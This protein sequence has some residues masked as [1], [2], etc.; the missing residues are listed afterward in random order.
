MVG[1]AHGLVGRAH[2]RSRWNGRAS[3]GSRSA[4]AT[5][6][7]SSRK[8]R[9]Q[10]HRRIPPATAR[11]AVRRPAA[12]IRSRHLE[13][14][15]AVSSASSSRRSTAQRSARC[16]C[17]RCAHAG[18]PSGRTAARVRAARDAAPAAPAR[19]RE[20]S[21]AHC[22]SARSA[23]DLRRA[24]GRRSA[25]RPGC[26]ASSSAHP[27]VCVPA[28]KEVDFFSYRYDRG[29]QWY[30][31]CFADR[32]CR[33]R[34]ARGE[35]SPSYFCEPA[36]PARVARIPAR[37]EDHRFAARS[38]AAGLV[39]PST[40]GQ[41]RPPDGRR[42]ELRARAAQQPDVRRAGSVRDAPEELAAAFS[43]RPDPR[44]ADGR[45][46]SRP[47]RRVPHASTGS[48]ASTTS[49]AAARASTR[50]T[51]AAMRRGRPRSRSS[52]MRPT[53]RRA[54]PACAGPGTPRRARA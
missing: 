2:A 45:R 1:R 34:V 36:V 35:I 50:A 12:A 7:G 29:Y 14:R 15:A 6:C 48:W 21:R 30:E 4:R 37:R 25:P 10:L 38:R 54:R 26:I 9:T 28:V 49:F 51:T 19:V 46:R 20:M 18:A 52:R 16:S 24:S 27:Q 47:A 23:A 3:S 31:R 22:A 33:R 42:P 40:R 5:G 11:T 41:G 13:T 43:A 44:R 39:E 32:P 53:P 17:A 8:L